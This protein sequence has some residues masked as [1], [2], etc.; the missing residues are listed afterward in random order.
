MSYEITFKDLEI[1]CIEL[2]KLK[3]DKIDDEI[4][5]KV[6]LSSTTLDIFEINVLMR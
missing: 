5:K 3:E 1:C 2:A 4:K 6:T